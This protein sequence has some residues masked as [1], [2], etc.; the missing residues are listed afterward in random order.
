MRNYRHIQIEPLTPAIG[1][2]VFGVDLAAGMSEDVLDEIYSALIDH[3]VIF[4]KG[5]AIT[6]GDHLKFAESFGDPEPPHPIYPHHPECKQVVVLH[7]GPHNPPDTDGWHTDVT[8]RKTPPFASI[9]WAKQ[10]PS[11]GGDTL[12]TSLISAYES[13]PQGIQS[14]IEELSAVHDMGDFRN[15]FAVGESDGE[16]V[17]EAHQ[18]FGSAIHP[19]VQTHP[20]SGKKF[21]FANEGFTQHIVG[22]KASDSSQLL[23]LLYHHINQ[24]EHQVRFRWSQGAIAMWDNRCTWHYA[25]ADYLPNERIMHRITVMNDGR[26]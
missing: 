11:I 26:L 7:T 25:T 19:L 18:R 8:F 15:D 6:V 1:A 3:H 21:V 9:L 17:T 4:M 20:V 16:R 22:L 12:W 2:E 14:E 13:L 23:N 24:P 5:Q 10:I